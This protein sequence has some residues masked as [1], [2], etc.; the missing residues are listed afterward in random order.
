M[1]L[2]A[3]VQAKKSVNCMLKSM[4][5]PPAGNGAATGPIGLLV[6]ST[7]IAILLGLQPLLLDVAEVVGRLEELVGRPLA[8]HPRVR[9]RLVRCVSLGRIDLCNK[10]FRQK[11]CNVTQKENIDFTEQVAQQILGAL[12]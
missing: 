4:R 7:A 10:T 9:K 6:V 3:F 8:G 5:L 11:R 1:Y 12:G 2:L